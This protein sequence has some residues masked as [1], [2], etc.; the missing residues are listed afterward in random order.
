VLGT[1]LLTF[2]D[3]DPRLRH[4]SGQD[5]WLDRGS[6]P[7]IRL[8]RLCLARSSPASTRHG[9]DDSPVHRRADGSGRATRDSAVGAAAAQQFS[10]TSPHPN[11]HAHTD[12]LPC[13]GLLREGS[14]WT[15]WWGSLDGM[16]EVRGSNPLSS[17]PG[18]RSFPPS[19]ARE[20]GLRAADT[21]QPPVRGRSAHPGRRSPMDHRPH[22]RLR[23]P[24]H[25]QVPSTGLT[26]AHLCPIRARASFRCR[27]TRAAPGRAGSHT[28]S[29]RCWDSRGFRS[30]SP[31]RRTAGCG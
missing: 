6:M 28:R 26:A 29:S 12:L 8:R 1:W 9:G 2:N 31:R 18:Q 7:V 20:S 17:T 27:C 19:T 3:R 22:A 13:H 16:Q 10:R 15:L 11:H 14:W 23:P 5:C 25:P 30:V 21:Q 4:A 24:G